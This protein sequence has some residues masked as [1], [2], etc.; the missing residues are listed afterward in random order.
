[1]HSTV[2]TTQ[3]HQRREALKAFEAALAP[4]A[5]M[6]ADGDIDDYLGALADIAAKLVSGLGA[7][8]EQPPA[9]NVH[10]GRVGTHAD[11]DRL[12]YCASSQALM[13]DQA[14]E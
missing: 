7:P 8:A 11:K 10:I 12:A 2:Q 5:T 13:R 14:R 3:A 9:A 6:T 4:A 1:M